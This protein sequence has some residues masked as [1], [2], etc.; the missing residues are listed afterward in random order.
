VRVQEVGTPL[1]K[2]TSVEVKRL[3][4]SLLGHVHLALGTT[5]NIHALLGMAAV[6][7]RHTLLRSE[8][9]LLVAMLVIGGFGLEAS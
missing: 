8:L 5:R 7:V 4:D 9:W 3:L 6:D 1:R 2:V